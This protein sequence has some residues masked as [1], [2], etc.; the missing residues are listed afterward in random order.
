MSCDAE[1]RISAVSIEA[2]R[3][4]ADLRAA[5]ALPPTTD[6]WNALHQVTLRDVLRNRI[7][8]MLARL[9]QHREH[10]PADQARIDTL[11]D[12][13]IRVSGDTPS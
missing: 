1:Q 7:P 3:L 13:F 5:L 8:A 2:Q 6:E 4:L 12:E 9:A 11:I 10:P